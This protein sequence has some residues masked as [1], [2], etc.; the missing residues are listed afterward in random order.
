MIYLQE[1][2]KAYSYFTMLDS[3]FEH[4]IEAREMIIQY[5][6]EVK[7][8]VDLIKFNKKKD[9]KAN[10][11]ISKIPSTFSETGHTLPFYDSTKKLEVQLNSLIKETNVIVENHNKM[12]FRMK[13]LLTGVS[14][15]LSVFEGFEDSM[16]DVLKS[17]LDKYREL[18]KD[19][20]SMKEDF[21]KQI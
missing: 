15:E 20:V 12:L 18:L 10:D 2:Q 4:F 9:I 17:K 11:Y 13:S 3:D 21:I 1:Q 14:K 8:L 6:N 7:D 19:I 16:D 5:R